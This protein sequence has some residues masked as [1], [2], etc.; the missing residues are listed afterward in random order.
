M[1]DGLCSHPRRLP[2]ALG[3]GS[4]AAANR[5]ANRLANR[6]GR[7]FGRTTWTSPY[8]RDRSS[9]P[10]CASA[11]ADTPTPTRLP[12]TGAGPTTAGHPVPAN[13]GSTR[14]P[15]IAN[16][17]PT[18]TRT[19]SS[20]RSSDAGRGEV[21]GNW[22]AISSHSFVDGDTLDRME[23]KVQLSEHWSVES[24]QIRRRFD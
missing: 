18:T 10:W 1:T 13:G 15:G 20:S 21:F 17:A 14:A 11:I 5:L 6:P 16:L 4:G 9:I 23:C 24:M 12:G 19:R 3:I 22:R 8:G 7:G 2:A